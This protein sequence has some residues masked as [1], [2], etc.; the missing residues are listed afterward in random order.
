MIKIG[1]NK[2]FKFGFFTFAGIILALAGT[3]V[4]AQNETLLESVE[5]LVRHFPRY[6]EDA[7][8]LDDEFES[9]D[10]TNQTKLGFGQNQCSRDLLRVFTGLRKKQMWAIEGRSIIVLSCESLTVRPMSV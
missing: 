7:L 3:T 9:E 2:M 5:D 4:C 10:G 8:S 1:K 6:L